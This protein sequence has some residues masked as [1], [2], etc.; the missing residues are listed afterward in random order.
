MQQSGQAIGGGRM[1]PLQQICDSPVACSVTFRAAPR[2]A[3]RNVLRNMALCQTVHSGGTIMKKTILAAICATVIGVT[4]FAAMA[5]ATGSSGQD[6]TKMGTGTQGMSKE[7]MSKDGMKKESMHK[8]G[9]HKDN[10]KKDNM[11]KKN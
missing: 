4:P 1:P 7:G 5:Q 11:M 9:M 8:D 10:M 2:I 3:G 6:S